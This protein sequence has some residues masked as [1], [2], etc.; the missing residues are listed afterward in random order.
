[1][2][3]L[4]G[5]LSIRRKEDEFLTAVNEQYLIPLSLRTFEISLDE[6]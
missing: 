2:S 4:N 5:V 3:L 6:I 1:M